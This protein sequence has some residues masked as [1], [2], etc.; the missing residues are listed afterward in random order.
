M[1][2]QEQIAA[3][4]ANAQH[5]TGPRTD[6]GKS[7]VSQN[8]VTHGLTAR[9]I[10]PRTPG[11]EIEFP[12]IREEAYAAYRPVGHTEVLLVDRIVHARCSLVRATR[13]LGELETGTLEDVTNP[14]KDKPIARLHRY[15]D[16]HDR[17]ERRALRALKAEQTN[18]GRKQTSSGLAAGPA[19]PPPLANGDW[20]FKNKKAPPPPKAA[21]GSY[22]EAAA[23]ADAIL[24]QEIAKNGP[25]PPKLRPFVKKLLRNS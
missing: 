9:N 21:R 23:K 1:T 7:A 19:D 16:M 15:A 11:E 20:I 25:I 3:N 22:E 24:A 5:S 18:R 12:A 14:E 2:T 6:T 13:L 4:K 10:I 17:A 8:A